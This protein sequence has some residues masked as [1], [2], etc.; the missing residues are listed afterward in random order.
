M[1]LVDRQLGL[2][3]EA[4]DESG[5]RVALSERTR[6]RVIPPAATGTGRPAGEARQEEEQR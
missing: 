2:I 5:T 6:F 4:L 3:F 1:T